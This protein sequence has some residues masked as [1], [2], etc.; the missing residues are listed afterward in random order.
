MVSLV[1]KGCSVYEFFSRRSPYANLQAMVEVPEV[2]RH[3]KLRFVPDIVG[4][5]N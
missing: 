3:T 1:D 5:Q 4:T 2:T